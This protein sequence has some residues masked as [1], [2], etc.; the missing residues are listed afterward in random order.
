MRKS[1]VALG[2]IVLAGASAVQGQFWDPP[3]LQNRNASGFEYYMLQVP[4][5]QTIVSDGYD[6]DWGW[7]DPDYVLTM[8]EWRDEGERPLPT[9]DD[10][11]V[12]TKM[13]WKGAPDNRWYVFMAAHDD[14][15]SHEGTN[16]ARWDGDMI[17]I[18]IDYQ[19]HGRTRGASPCY[20]QEW[21]AAAGNT[22]VNFSY[23]YPESEGG[24]GQVAWAAYGR[25]PW[26]NSKVRVEPAEAW[27]ADSW[28][29]DTGGDTYYEFD[30]A[31][32][33]LLDDAGPA[34]SEPA[35]LNAIAGADGKGLPFNFFYEDGDPAFNNDMTVRGAEASARQYF[36]HALLL[37][38]GEYTAQNPTAVEA[39]TWGRIKDSF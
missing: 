25:A 28:T 8:D 32:V 23:R 27:G 22:T 6:S 36:A 10:L 26:A 13:A 31:L 4:A 7:F 19:D 20:G 30:I 33:K 1:L 15:L 24:P 16:V 5:G 17:G 37:K 34:A 29:S 12:T 14:T 21:V 35:D 3:T 39:T 11:D 9:R 2:I 38:V 18:Q